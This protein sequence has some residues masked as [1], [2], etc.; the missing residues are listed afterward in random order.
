MATIK[1]ALILILV[2]IGIVL[3]NS[4]YGRIGDSI[5]IV[6]L[7][8]LY[9]ST[10]TSERNC[11]LGCKEEAR[12]YGADPSSFTIL[13]EGYSKD[14]N[15]VYYDNKDIQEAGSTGY[16]VQK[17][18][19]ADPDS[20]RVIENRY[21][22]DSQNVY[23]EGQGLGL[24]PKTTITYADMDNKYVYAADTNRIFYQ[25][26]L[27]EEAQIESF[28]VIENALSK[29]N[30]SLFFRDLTV[31]D[32][33]FLELNQIQLIKHNRKLTHNIDGIDRSVLV[34]FFS[35]PNNTYCLH[36][37]RSWNKETWQDDY[38]TYLRNIPRDNV[39][40]SQGFFT[41]TT[42]AA[43]LFCNKLEEADPETFEILSPSFARDKNNVY[44]EA[45]IIEVKD[46]NSL[47]K[48][49][50]NDF[51]CVDYIKDKYHVYGLF[52]NKFSPPNASEIPEKC[53]ERYNKEFN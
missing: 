11:P 20:F 6:K 50:H 42:D 31:T 36:A 15:N 14:K 13:E 38:T 4:H 25:D 28:K 37:L 19:E 39:I 22:R 45:G 3:I 51:L 8:G 10:Y 30:S 17:V 46:K 24:D 53:I 34:N 18:P 7:N 49:Y 52:G 48:V 12:I 29:D 5:Y 26:R 35:T 27:I 9:H 44:S 33:P 32:F 1:K 40:A 43:Y 21:W 16:D 47:E 23:F 2:V 41:L